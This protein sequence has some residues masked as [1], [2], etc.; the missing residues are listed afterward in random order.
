MNSLLGG[1]PLREPSQD[2]GAQPKQAEDSISLRR[3]VVRILDVRRF[4]TAE[5]SRHD[6]E[7]CDDVGLEPCDAG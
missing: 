7:V 2:W 3:V 1:H 4:S 5:G 6:E